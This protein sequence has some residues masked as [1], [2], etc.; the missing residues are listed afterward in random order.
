MK[1]LLVLL[2]VSCLVVTMT[3]AATTLETVIRRGKLIVATDLTAIPMQYRDAQGKPTGFV[4]EMMELAAEKLGVVLE[5][6]D[7]AWESLIPSLTSR[8][9]DMIAANM[10]ML[11]TRAKSIRFS[12]PYFLTGVKML[13][14]ADTKV[15]SWEEFKDPKLRIGETMGS[16]HADW[17]E[18]NWKRDI[19]LYDNMAEWVTELKNGRI[20]G[21]MD[22]EMLVL[23]IVKRE[24]TLKAL[25]GYIRVDMYGLA[26]NQGTDDDSIV[27]WFNLFLKWIKLTGEY[28]DIYE[29]YVGTE[30]QPT[31]V[32][33]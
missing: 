22:D 6:R 32:I 9:V 10:S 5:W 23:D 21:V 14:R 7:M 15:E 29:K 18:A 12:D 28:G 13:V 31:W 2:V 4:V 33:D 24:P 27:D 16:S 1:K 19:H 25:P 17:I 11:L 30:W 3:L 26:F 8:K 20:D